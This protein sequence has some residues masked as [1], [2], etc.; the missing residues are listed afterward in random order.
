MS[1]TLPGTGKVIST[2]V[3]NSATGLNG[4]APTTGEEV[5]L[6]KLAYGPVGFLTDVS[7]TDPLPVTDPDG[8][9]A[10]TV[11]SSAVA[12]GANAVFTGTSEDVGKYSTIMVTVFAD[13][14]SATDGLQMQQSSNGTNWDIGDSF[15]IPASTGKTFSV[16]VQAKFFRIV[17]TNGAT[18]QGAFRLQTLIS[19]YAKKF[20]S[21]RPQDGR[22][23]D[24]DFEEQL[25]Y[26]MGFDGTNWNRLRA[27]IANGL[28]AD[29]SRIVAALP[30]GANTIGAVTGPAAAALALDA[31]LSNHS[32]RFQAA[33][34]CVTTLSAANATVTATLSAVASQFHYIT[35]IEIV[36]V[37]TAAVAG[38]AILGY[39]S[40]NLPGTWARSAGNA[41]AAGGTVKDVDEVLENPIKS[42]AVNTA[43]TIVAPAAGAACQVRITIYYYVA[44]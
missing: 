44:P 12:L 34:L 42:S 22:T 36:R 25:A 8:G 41:I 19:R 37:A 21:V 13:Q 1:T 18:A 33:T 39:T 29:V 20:S 5:Q 14:A 17:Y 40:T 30:T 28:L 26:M 4:G 38:T 24:N 27:S 7:P 32:M 6:L 11:N 9:I 10:S 15:S 3:L 35:R 2:E 43:T 31:T 16:G 23:N